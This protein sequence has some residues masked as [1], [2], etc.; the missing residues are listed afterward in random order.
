MDGRLD[1]NIWSQATV[2]DDLH[3]ITPIE[4]TEPTEYT[5]VFLLYT[6]DAL[7]VGVE[8]QYEDPNQ[9][10]AKV[11]RQGEML[12][13]DDMFAVIL[14]PFHDRRSGYRFE[15]N[16]NGIRSDLIFQNTNQRQQNWDGIWQAASARNEQGWTAEM[17]IPFKTLSFNPRNDSWGINFMR[18]MPQKAEWIGWVSRNRNQNP[19]IAGTATGFNNLQQGLGLDIVPSFRL[20]EQRDYLPFANQSFSEP[21]LDMFYKLTPGLNASLT[22]NTDFSATEVDDRQVDLSRLSLIHICRCRRIERCR[23]RWSPYH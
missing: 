6:N 11:L 3:Q 2:V 23:S 19:S 18:W 14:D 1:E 7:Y 17:R 4:Y 15:V 16:A 13:G 10:T 8:L 5:R 20:S 12:F 9:V 21:S 22:V